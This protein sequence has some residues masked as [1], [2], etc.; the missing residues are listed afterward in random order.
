MTPIPPHKTL[1]LLHRLVDRAL[2]PLLEPMALEH[3]TEGYVTIDRAD[4]DAL[5]SSGMG[6]PQSV[7]TGF[8]PRAIASGLMVA[9][10]SFSSTVLS[11]IWR[12][13]RN[14]GAPLTHVEGEILR[15]FLARIVGAWAEGDKRFGVAGGSTIFIAEVG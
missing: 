3:A 12:S 11:R 14:Q 8:G 5:G 15:Q 7:L 2:A 4:I 1:M 13:D 10:P 6:D 9:E